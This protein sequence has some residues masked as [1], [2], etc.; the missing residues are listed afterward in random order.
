MQSLGLR[1]PS[2]PFRPRLVQLN[3]KRRIRFAVVL[4]GFGHVGTRTTVFTQ[5]PVGHLA[6][7]C[8]NL[9]DVLWLSLYHVAL[10]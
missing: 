5:F 3:L 9:F 8:A 4:P 2:P 7:A 10:F 6:Q 1:V